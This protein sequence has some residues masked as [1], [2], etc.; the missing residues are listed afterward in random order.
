[1]NNNMNSTLVNRI[2]ATMLNSGMSA[3]TKIN[4]INY[5]G[6][7]ITVDYADI[8]TKI[9]KGAVR[10]T[11]HPSKVYEV[12]SW[13]TRCRDKAKAAGKPVRFIDVVGNEGVHVYR[14]RYVSKITAYNY[15]QPDC[16]DYL[17]LVSKHTPT[18]VV[19]EPMTLEQE[20]E[21]A[22]EVAA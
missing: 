12:K 13:L 8:T 15:T 7:H 1:M 16:T 4:W 17:E 2:A 18:V 22:W 11:V 9:R 10:V 14:S 20:V 6:S 5:L 19:P 3:K 21:Q